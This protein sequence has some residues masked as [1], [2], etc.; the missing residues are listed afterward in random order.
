MP[1]QLSTEFLSGGWNC[2]DAEAN[3]KLVDYLLEEAKSDELAYKD[4][5]KLWTRAST[6][7]NHLSYGRNQLRISVETSA[8]TLLTAFDRYDHAFFTRISE[9]VSESLPLQF[10]KQ[11][12]DRLGAAGHDALD[13]VINE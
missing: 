7:K 1:K 2:W 5:R 10:F 3:G 12:G 13:P 6:N 9:K 4:L 11:L 8:T